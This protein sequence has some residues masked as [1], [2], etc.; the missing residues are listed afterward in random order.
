M[1][2]FFHYLREVSGL[3]VKVQDFWFRFL[4]SVDEE[5]Q[6]PQ[7]N[8]KLWSFLYETIAAAA[9]AIVVVCIVFAFGFRC[10]GVVG[11]S[12][13]PTLKNGDWLLVT[14]FFS[15]VKPGDIVITTQPNTMN[16]SLVKRVIAKGGDTVDIDFETHTVMVNG[17]VLDEKYIAEPTA[18]SGDIQFPLT[19]EN[20]KIFVMGDNRNDSMD[21]RYSTIGCIDEDYVLGIAKY[22]VFPFGNF[23]LK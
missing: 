22:R 20:G 8:S 14:S 23:N 5:E 21:S 15:D 18:Q 4:R 2:G 1:S 16:E 6:E 7:K 12:M 9:T 3:Q 19:V 17:K 11:S 10:V 13:M